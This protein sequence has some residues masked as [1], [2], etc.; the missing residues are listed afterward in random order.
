[1]A[2][3]TDLTIRPTFDQANKENKQN[4]EKENW[5]IGENKLEKRS[6]EQVIHIMT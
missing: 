3:L 5:R 6:H 1:M 2:L 4:L